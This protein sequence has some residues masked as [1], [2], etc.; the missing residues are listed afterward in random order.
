MAVSSM[1]V[2][3]RSCFAALP[4]DNKELLL[5]N[6]H[7]LEE[8]GLGFDVPEDEVIW[9]YVKDFAQQYHHVPEVSTLRNHFTH[10]NEAAVL[11]RLDVIALG[12][13]KSQGD[14]LAAL[15]EKAEERRTR[16]VTEILREAARIVDIGVEVK[17]GRE[18]RILRGPVDAVKYM[19][20]ESHDIIAP[21]T[22]GR[23]S[24]NI[25]SDGMSFA[26]EVD[27]IETNPLAGIGQMS[28]LRQ[29]DDALRGA[30]RGELWTHAA[31]TGNMKSTLMLNWAYNQ[32]IFYRHS[33]IIFSIEMPYLQ[34]RRI[35]YALHS[36]HPKFEE[37]RQFF[38]IKKC[39]SYKAI[40][41]GELDMV[42]EA[43]LL[44]LSQQDRDALI[45][46]G[47]RFYNPMRPEKKFLTE[48]VIPDMND[49]SNEYGN[50][51][52]EVADPDKSDFTVADARHKAEL[53]FTKDPTIAALYIDHAGLMASRHY[54]NST[55]ERTNEVIRDLKRLSM[56]FNR[57]LGIAVVN[58]F[59][60]S[61]EGYK[62]AEKNGGRYNLTHLSY[63]NETEKS[64]D[65][66][67]AGWIDDNLKQQALLKLQCL[68]SRDDQPFEDFYAGILWPC[69][70]L[71]TTTAVGVEVA[72]EVGKDIDRLLG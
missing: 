62:A 32:A 38:G 46:I 68:K 47:G 61:R 58:L 40:R 43:Q 36:A 45:E 64:S 42:T 35:L 60:I 6:V 66:V 55:T 44:M 30:R 51:H 7:A 17:E 10:V 12:P 65:I 50:I 28:G 23:I 5:R 20:S 2:L 29:M 53:L 8:S 22:G 3:L 24:G 37:A 15:N 33:N 39:L 41:D 34:V 14:F 9:K 19:L 25:M 56:S 48:Y 27:R 67:T 72:K 18:K 59:Q 57:G 70:R 26:D 4:T 63:A 1:K 49:P 71:F 54:V 11:D 69:R 52:I 21:T 13:P 16:R 31:F